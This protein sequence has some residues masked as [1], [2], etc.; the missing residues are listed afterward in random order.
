MP[1]CSAGPKV[2]PASEG[3][4]RREDD[5]M[6]RSQ[7]QGVIRSGIGMRRM[8][9]KWWEPRLFLAL[10]FSDT[11][12][13][14]REGGRR[15]KMRKVN[16]SRATDGGV[17]NTGQRRRRDREPCLRPQP[18]EGLLSNSSA[19]LHQS[20]HRRAVFQPTSPPPHSSTAQTVRVTKFVSLSRCPGHC[21]SGRIA[22]VRQR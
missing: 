22:R 21:R 20:S 11:T 19:W 10:E 4:A 14:R 17:N 16:Q 3:T 7:G 12:P 1:G 8:Q 13:R 9:M 18:A 2:G 15:E 5:E 6:V